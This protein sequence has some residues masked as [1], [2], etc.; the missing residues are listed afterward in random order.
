MNATSPILAFAILLLCSFA[1]GIRAEE[2]LATADLP[3]VPASVL[4]ES[5]REASSTPSSS[6]PQTV[7][8]APGITE[9]IPVAVGH[10]NRIVTP[11]DHP[12]VRTVSAATT[13]VEGNVLYVATQEESPVT[14]Y[15]TP[16]DTED[17]ALSI[18]LAPRRIPPHEI[19]LVLDQAHYKKLNVL[20]SSRDHGSSLASNAQDY[21]THLKKTLR[22]LALGR[23]PTG[24]A[25]RTPGFGESISCTQPGLTTQTGQ[26]FEGRDLILLVGVAKNTGAQE[27]E[28]DERSCVDGAG[29]VVAVAAWPNPVLSPGGSTE[30]Y[31]VIRRPSDEDQT[32]R[33]SLLMGSSQP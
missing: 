18:T 6:G 10:L 12:Q 8:I 13:L 2:E 20:Q 27:T 28:I 16:G 26:A 33:P 14:L 7:K 25:M 19:R 22:A 32:A 9:V 15:I 30:L 5:R 21:I 29:D 31:V 1:S 3:A 11:F 17:L 24:Y 23:Q 4:A